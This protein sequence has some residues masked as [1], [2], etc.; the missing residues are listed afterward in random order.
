[1]AKLFIFGIG[2]TGSRVIKALSMLL[3]SGVK[4][5]NGIDIV[6]P[7]MI[8]PDASN[9]DLTRTVDILKKY[10]N[11]RS[12]TKGSKH[13]FNVEI[14]T[15]SDLGADE[16]PSLT[17]NFKFLI[18]EAKGKFGEFIDYFNLDSSDKALVDLLFSSANI[19]ANMTVGF[20]GNPN[21][22][23][24]VLNKFRDSPEYAAFMNH[25]NKGDS[26]FIIS[27]IFGGTGAAG[28]PLLLKN[29][30][31]IQPGVQ[32]SEIIGQSKIGAIS[33]LPY[34]KVQR[35]IELNQEIDSATFIGKT[36]AA[37]HYYEHAILSGRSLNAFY[38]LGNR[39]DT[40]MPYAE[41]EIA[42]KNRAHFLEL[43]GA[44]G[45]VDYTLMLDDLDGNET[46]FK[47]FG[48]RNEG[49]KEVKFKN[50]GDETEEQLMKALSKFQLLSLFLNKSLKVLKE[51][52]GEFYMGEDGVDH[53]F[54][55]GIFFERQLKPFL[56]HF[57]EWILELT[58]ESCD[59]RF[60]P[61]HFNQ[62]HNNLFEFIKDVEIKGSFL[63]RKEVSGDEVIR[64]ADLIVKK[65]VYSQEDVSTRFL[66]LMD[67]V[68]E[69]RI[70]KI[71]N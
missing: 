43:A 21:I 59:P 56:K 39:S 23:S 35:D 29:L 70:N 18:P 46:I 37:L 51:S 17:N 3:A 16:D 57:D 69:E 53:S 12:K 58:H 38:S 47:E 5:G 44:L 49:N 62:E 36:K 31:D 66:R 8:D 48:I 19:E 7:I 11:I 14:K 71:L 45:I 25:F 40:E 10:Q 30:R 61:F 42:Q 22:G 63:K 54:Y 28:F 41:G 33:Y 6:V 60:S 68:L 13:F 4:L 32:N 64:A 9:G 65:G 27:S 52:R 50:L 55:K 67:D 34:F 26:I 20:K 24:V 1:M 15:L 2:G